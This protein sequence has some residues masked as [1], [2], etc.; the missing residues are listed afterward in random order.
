VA[1]ESQAGMETP[2]LA[3]DLRALFSATC[4]APAPTGIPPFSQ[5]LWEHE[6]VVFLSCLSGQHYLHRAGICVYQ[7]PL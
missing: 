7:C 3:G 6:R 1:A 4:M 2:E 5:G